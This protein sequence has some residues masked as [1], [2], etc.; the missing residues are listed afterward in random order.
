M[1]EGRH[2]YGTLITSPSPRWPAVVAT[3]GLDFVFLDTEHTAVDRHQL[4][5]M[6]QTYAAMDLAP[7]VRVPSADLFHVSTALD[8]GAHG[9]IIPYVEN[10]EDVRRLVGAVKYRPLKGMLLEAYLSGEKPLNDE[11]RS[12]LS[13][14][15]KNNLLIV[16]IE[17][18]PAL[19]NLDAILTVNGLDAILIGPHDLTTS[20]GVP[21]QFNH[22]TYLQA[23]DGAILKARSFGLG[24]G[25]HVMYRDA[26]SQWEHW[27]NLGANLIIH[28]SDVNAFRN[29]LQDE[30]VKIK[31]AVGDWKIET[32]D[33]KENFI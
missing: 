5:W 29:A 23:V 24:A 28:W 11:T 30:L 31:H 8:G 22:P 3:L 25:V 27:T 21:E 13:Q 20:L 7:V 10:P 19:E 14:Y 6:C 15:N 18:I 12:Y 33:E 26:V 1:H 2:V 9:I 4:S 17:S 16:N 32:L